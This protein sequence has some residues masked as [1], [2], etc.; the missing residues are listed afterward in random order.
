LK[1]AWSQV[2]GKQHV[3]AF[4]YFDDYKK[5]VSST[6]LELTVLEVQEKVLYYQK[7]KD[8]T[9]ELKTLGAHN[10]TS[11]RAMHLTGKQRIK[12]FLGAYENFR[13]ADGTLPASYQVLF[14]VLT[15]GR[16]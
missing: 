6:T 11:H 2:D 3:N 8:L 16:T 12:Q 1:T 7:V 10:M 15:K 9:R 14:G 13:L 4:A 5:A